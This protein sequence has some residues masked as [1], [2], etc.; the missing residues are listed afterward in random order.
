[1]KLKSAKIFWFPILVIFFGLG[2]FTE[3]LNYS[4]SIDFY[5]ESSEL[6]SKKGSG[7]KKGG[8]KKGGGK[9]G[10]GKKSGAKKKGDNK[11]QNNLNKVQTNN[12]AMRE[13]AKERYKKWKENKK[14]KKSNLDLDLN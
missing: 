1:M 4:N 14:A 10:G 9:K 6:I 3:A 8:A 13:E 7:G 2:H 11:I 5:N 12:E